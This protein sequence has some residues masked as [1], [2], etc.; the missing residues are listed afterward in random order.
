MITINNY[1]YYTFSNL[2]ACKDILESF[3]IILEI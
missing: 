2:N 1:N 3:K